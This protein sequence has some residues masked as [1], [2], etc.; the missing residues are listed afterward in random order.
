MSGPTCRVLRSLESN[1]PTSN[2]FDSFKS[3]RQDVRGFATASETPRSSGA[4]EVPY[5]TSRIQPLGPAEVVK[6]FGSHVD[7]KSGNSLLQALQKRR[8]DGMLDH[9]IKNKGVTPHMVERGLEYL[10]AKYP[11]DEEAAIIRR[12]EKEEEFK[13]QEA[14]MEIEK[15]RQWR[16]QE[17]AKEDGIYGKSSVDE[18]VK[19]Y[20]EAQK[21]DREAREERRRLEFENTEVIYEEEHAKVGNEIQRKI[22]EV[23]IIPVGK[24]KVRKVVSTSYAPL[25]KD[26]KEQ[27]KQLSEKAARPALVQAPNSTIALRKHEDWIN[28]EEKWW[29]KYQKRAYL[30]DWDGVSEPPYMPLWR[31]WGLPTLFMLLTVG[32]SILFGQYYR[33]PQKPARIFP[34]IPPAAA[35]IGAIIS[36]NV[37]I[38]A[39]WKFPPMWRFLNK[40]FL[41]HAV[42]PKPFQLL[43]STFSHQQFSHLAMNMA[44][45]WFVGRYC[46]L[47]T[48]PILTQ[49]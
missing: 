34:D 19:L 32:A 13:E 46:E 29:H 27:V 20:N 15:A 1:S 47:Q 5:A 11:I 18:S 41:L 23:H 40:N 17:S 21:K 10:R 44:L 2:G 14:L 36:L 35:T 43:G 12:I 33:P 16:P 30:T 26:I 48:N 4:R 49:F 25:T 24:T 8:F 22:S 6:I 3:W 45:L 37:F 39:A 42:I 28:S 9:A 31:R 38:L 7:A